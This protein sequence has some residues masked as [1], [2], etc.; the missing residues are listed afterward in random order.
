MR[1]LFYEACYDEIFIWQSFKVYD[2]MF[3][4]IINM[5]M[6]CLKLNFFMIMMHVT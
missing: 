6:I 2:I 3:L 4:Q 1:R 5:I